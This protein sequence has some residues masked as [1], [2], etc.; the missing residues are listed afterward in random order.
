MKVKN[1]FIVGGGLMGTGIAQVAITAG[2]HV[3]L[4]DLNMGILE[5][6]RTSI[7]KMLS[8]S[9]SKGKMSTED[10]DAAMTR[11]T[12]SEDLKSAQSADMVIEA[13]PERVDVKKALFA[14]L[15]VICRE[16][17][18]F[19][20]NTSSISI[21]NISSA[22]KK[23]ERFVGM[24]FFSPV[25]LME[26]VEIVKGLGTSAETVAIARAVGEQFGK[27]CIVVKDS[28]GFVVNRMLVPMLNEACFLLESGIGSIE[29]IDTGM[30]YGLNHPIGPFELMDMSGID[31]ALAALEVIF[32]ETGDTKYR[33]AQ[34][35]LNMR[36]MGW[37]GQ[38]TDKGFYVYHEDGTKTP[39]PDIM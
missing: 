19:V 29:D 38:K 3:T 10:K 12:L 33:P 7:E 30:R 36:R 9:M 14:E 27:K 15:S 16:D 24:H 35:L 2:Y 21:A 39:N 34:L 20:S 22:V 8:K 26:L 11:L 28:P 5:K 13:A 37:L 31:V 18:T 1:I 6:A 32:N 25:P 4:Y 17:T 23:P